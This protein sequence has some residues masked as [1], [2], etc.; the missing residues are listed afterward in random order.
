L[1]AA[2]VT[3]ALLGLCAEAAADP[4]RLIDT[5]RG[6]SENIATDLDFHLT[7]IEDPFFVESSSGYEPPLPE[8]DLSD[9]PPDGDVLAK[10][11]SSDTYLRAPEPPAEVLA[12]AAIAFFGIFEMLRRI[13]QHGQRQ[14][15]SGRRRRVRTSLRMMA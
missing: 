7:L 5:T 13:L 11:L 9:D 8:T 4:I 2:W 15:S 10:T 12:I 1:K 3:A 14:K 6:I